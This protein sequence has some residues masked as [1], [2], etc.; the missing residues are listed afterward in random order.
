MKKEKQLE[1]F[2]AFWKDHW[3][4]CRRLDKK[5]AADQW[6]K[7]SPERY[8]VI[9]AALARQKKQASWNTG[10]CK[11][12]PYPHRWLRD[13]RWEDEISLPEDKDAETLV[14]ALGRNES[15]PPDFPR[16]IMVRFR[17]MCARMRWTWPLLHAWLAKDP[18][19]AEQIKKEY[20]TTK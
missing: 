1:A 3:P 14:E 11:F 12:V 20:L 8:P 17:S 5:K 4:K 19:M 6:M 15:V 18:A 16:D 13:R 2:E 9:M 7:I 10:D